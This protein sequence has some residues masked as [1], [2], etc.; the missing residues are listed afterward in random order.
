MIYYVFCDDFS[1]H[2]QIRT[3]LRVRDM[4]TRESLSVE[5][6]M[7]V[8]ANVPAAT[9]PFSSGPFKFETRRRG[10][11]PRRARLLPFAVLAAFGCGT[12]DARRRAY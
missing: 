8:H 7:Q 11:P 2:A 10:A 6:R 4:H 12:A 3:S 9:R 5:T 1:D